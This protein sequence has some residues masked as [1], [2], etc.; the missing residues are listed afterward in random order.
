VSDLA[1]TTCALT[2]IV[3]TG[4]TLSVTSSSASGVNGTVSVT[5]AGGGTLSGTITATTC[6]PSFDACAALNAALTP[7]STGLSFCT[8]TPTCVP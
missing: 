5:L 6:V 4:G 2:P 7:G 1:A 8:T 3:V